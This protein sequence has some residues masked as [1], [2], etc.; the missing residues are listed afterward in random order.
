MRVIISMI[1]YTVRTRIEIM[2]IASAIIAVRIMS[3]IV[4]TAIAVIVVRFAKVEMIMVCI[5]NID[6]KTPTATTGINRSIK[7][8]NPYKT[9]IL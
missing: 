9:A 4:S 2:S 1:S 5:P 3:T 8:I 7:I 6:T